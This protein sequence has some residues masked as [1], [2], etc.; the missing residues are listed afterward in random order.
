MA[1]AEGGDEREVLLGAAPEAVARVR[2]HAAGARG[3]DPVVRARRR[4]RPG[5]PRRRGPR[6]S[7][8]R[9]AR[10]ASAAAPPRARARRRAWRRRIPSVR[11]RRPLHRAR[12]ASARRRPPRPRPPTRRRAGARALVL[13]ADPAH[14][15][16]DVLG[17]RL[18]PAPRALARAGRAPARRRRDRRARRAWS[19]TGARCATGW[20][21]CSAT[22]A[23]RRRWPR[24]WRCC[25][26]PRSSRRCSRSRSRR[27]AA[28]TTSS[29]STARR[30]A[31][32][33]G[34][35]R[36]PDLARSAF[37]VLLRVQQALAQVVT[38]LARSVFALPLPDAAVFRDAE[39]LL[40]RRLA[41]L[42]RLVV[43]RRH[44]RAP[45]GDAR[46]H[47]DRRG[48]ARPHGARALRGAL[49]RR[50]DEPAC[51]PRTPRAEAFFR[52]WSARAGGA[53][54]PRWRRASRRCRCCARR[55]ATTR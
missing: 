1:H 54:S 11:A 16:G 34:S 36:C 48:A 55:S 51:C 44:Q 17:E 19:A 7:P 35:S 22:R 27:G 30:R 8:A 5:R 41:R 37:R 45:R 29:S 28:P 33:C 42:R 12:E 39:A 18:G 3:V 23:S 6:R 38:P 26:A 53:R 4:P 13:S 9:S 24:S 47:G 2:R 15:L 46:A 14:S 31:R 25:R 52:D 21:R 43:G 10:A 49:R 32:R 40:Y 20:S 50:R